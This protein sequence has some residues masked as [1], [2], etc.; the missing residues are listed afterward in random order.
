M[1]KPCF[2]TELRRHGFSQRIRG[3]KFTYC[4]HYIFSLYTYLR[5]CSIN[6]GVRKWFSTASCFVNLQGLGTSDQDLIRIIVT[7]C[8]VDMVQIKQEFQ[9]RYG[10]SLE[11]FIQVSGVHTCIYFNI[12]S[13]V[14]QIGVNM[15]SGWGIN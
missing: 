12:P 8:E 3:L 1:F 9:G 15:H 6:P 4:K 10:K 13:N 11:S 5:T 14:N 2:I 7:R